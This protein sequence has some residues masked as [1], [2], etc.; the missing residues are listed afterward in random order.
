MQTS[1]GDV[2]SRVRREIKAVRQDSFLNDRFLFSLIVKHSNWLMKREDSAN[3]LLKFDSIVQ[4]LPLVP[5]VEVDAVEAAC[6]GIESGCMMKR[7]K[8]KLPELFDGYAG[9]LFRAVT[10][11][12]G[13]YEVSLTDPIIYVHI[14]NQSS[15]KYNK[16]L[17]GWFLNGHLFFP[18]LD[19]D[20]VRVEGIFSGDVNGYGCADCC[21][22]IPRQDQAFNV[23]AYLHGELEN[24]VLNDL[25][26]LLG[27]PGDEVEDK[28]SLTR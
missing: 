2:I 11:L 27:V 14:T 17:Y 28:K 16:S 21:T 9:P 6:R 18:R 19:W 15:H 3:K 7:T 1:I 5:L 26:G 12:D 10:S 13:R 8:D 20:A 25:K 4:S 23:P 22:C 24:H